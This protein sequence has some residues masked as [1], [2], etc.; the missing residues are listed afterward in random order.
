[1]HENILL[2]EKVLKC[3][4]GPHN[5][6]A[7]RVQTSK[8]AQNPFFH[9]PCPIN[10]NPKGVTRASLS[11]S[12]DPPVRL[13][14]IRDLLRSRRR[15]KGR[16]EVG[17]K[18]RKEERGEENFPSSQKLF[19]GVEKPAAAALGRG[20]R[21]RLSRSATARSRLTFLFGRNREEEVWRP[22]KKILNPPRAAR[23]ALFPNLSFFF[24]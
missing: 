24:A 2:V 8:V 7:R 9:P 14:L 4:L 16:K 23:L 10:L 13:T 20:E 3:T 17:G 11:P 18:E 1:M 19:C 21:K 15:R 12:R 6:E 22:F 5:V